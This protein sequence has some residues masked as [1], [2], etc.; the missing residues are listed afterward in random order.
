MDRVAID[1]IAMDRIDR[2]LIQ[3]SHSSILDAFEEYIKDF[4][5]STSVEDSVA[6]LNAISKVLEDA[7]ARFLS[8]PRL[9]LGNSR[10][11]SR[12]RTLSGGLASGH[13]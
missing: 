9:N 10:P 7:E 6:A 12:S 4:L 8:L 5:D 13:T 3:S 11:P 1:R 2:T